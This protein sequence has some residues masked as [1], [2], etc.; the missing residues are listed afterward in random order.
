MS[1]RSMAQAQRAEHTLTGIRRLAAGLVFIHGAARLTVGG[2]LPFG[3]WLDGIGFPLGI[4]IA[5]FVTAFELL[6]APLL[7]FGPRRWHS[8]I[9]LVFAAIYGFGLWLVHWPAGWFVVGLGRNGM[10]YS[11][12]LIGVFLAIAWRG[13]PESAFRRRR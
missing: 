7:A 5:A 8:P 13:W 9:A 2:V 1:E 3:A 10:E 11:V 12:C 6:G 4:G